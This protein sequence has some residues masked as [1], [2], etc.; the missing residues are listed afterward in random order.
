M[1]KVTLSWSWSRLRGKYDAR[2]RR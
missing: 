1:V 2:S